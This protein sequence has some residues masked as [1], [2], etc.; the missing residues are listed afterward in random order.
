MTNNTG[1]HSTPPTAKARA[2]ATGRTTERASA[3]LVPGRQ[4]L[5]DQALRCRAQFLGK[6]NHGARTHLRE[7]AQAIGE[8]DALGLD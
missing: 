8:P 1:N 3:D 6:L 4:A 2:E 7:L 5:I